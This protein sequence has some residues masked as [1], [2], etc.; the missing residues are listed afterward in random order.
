MKDFMTALGA[1]VFVG[2]A[3][4]AGFTRLDR[5]GRSAGLRDFWAFFVILSLLE[6]PK[7]PVGGPGDG[8]GHVFP[9]KRQRFRG[10]VRHSGRPNLQLR[11]T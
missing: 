3:G 6:T 2:G 1:D 5:L 9:S 4:L 7:G 10:R 8:F 11:R